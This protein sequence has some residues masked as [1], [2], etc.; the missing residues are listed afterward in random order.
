MKNWYELSDIDLKK[1]S[2]GKLGELLI[3]A[4]KTYYTTSSPIMSDHTYDTLEEI[5]KK[6]N[7]HHRIFKKVGHKNFNT[8]F[9]KQKHI[10]PM[11]SQAKVKTHE[12][13]QKYFNRHHLL[14]G[15]SYIIQPKC[16]GIS[17]EI[18]YKN[19]QAQDAIT[20]GSGITGDLVTQNASKMKGFIKSLPE[21]FTGSTRFETVITFTDFKKLKKAAKNEN[22]TNPRNSV[23]GITQRLDGKYTEFCTLFCI[24]IDH[25]SDKKDIP[26]EMERYSLIKKLGF[27]SIETIPCQNFQQIEKHFQNFLNNKRSSYPFE[28]DGLVIKINDIKL[29][30]SLG[31]I[32]NRPKGQVAYKFPNISQKTFIKKVTWQVGP[33]GTVTPV[34]Q[35][36]P[37]NIGGS[38]VSFASLANHDLIKEKNINVS[39]IVSIS[40]RGDV[41]PYIEKVIIKVKKGHISAPKKCPSCKTTLI[42]DNK[43]L[44]CPNQKKC[45]E[46]ILGRLNLFCQKLDIDGISKETIKKLYLAK[47]I[48]L[49]GDFYNLKINDFLNLEGLGEKSGQNILNQIKKKKIFTPQEILFSVSIPHLSLA[50]LKQ[51]KKAGYQTI[52]SILALTPDGLN[53]IPGFKETLSQKIIIGIKSRRPEIESLV[54]QVKVKTEKTSSGLENLIFCIT[55]KLKKPRKKTIEEIENKGGR[56]LST[57]SK[58]LNYLVS[59]DPT[60]SSTKTKKA[61]KLKIKIITEKDLEKILA[62][63]V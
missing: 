2:P 40:R 16:D 28:I 55:G 23:S 8:G 6:L 35:V 48:K 33:L 20:R 26:T 11:G 22:Y 44:K 50:R 57:V 1:I 34:A 56:V 36:D 41:I 18:I 27:K 24:D 43:Y 19:G 46:Q 51:L 14:P 52:P 10:I 17:M 59:N 32:N 31:F 5:L 25:K 9:K 30:K 53:N 61:K 49:P 54:K 4:K 39:D 12:E 58:N 63:K 37:V 42:K 7:P 21:P 47:K 3:E 29:Q 13:L 38:T 45:R 62:G 15:T 60:A